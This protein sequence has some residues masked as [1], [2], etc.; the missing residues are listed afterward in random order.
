[1]DSVE[2][3]TALLLGESM[4]HYKA[5]LRDN[6]RAEELRLDLAVERYKATAAAYSGPL[7]TGLRLERKG[8]TLLVV[9]GDR[10]ASDHLSARGLVR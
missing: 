9:R 4:E 10:Y 8:T 3:L 5:E 1:M 6:S 7:D 2:S